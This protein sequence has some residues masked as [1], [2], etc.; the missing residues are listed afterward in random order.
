MEPHHPTI[1]LLKSGAPAHELTPEDRA[2]GLAT[3]RRKQ[4]ERSRSM[5]DRISDEVQSKAETILRAYMESIKAGD[6]RAAE[7]LLDRTFG[8]ATQ[9]SEVETTTKAAEDMSLSELR[10]ALYARL[11]GTESS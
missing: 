3:R 10:A 11:E 2:R 1:R 5:L 8:K 4:A 7:A 9:R 6:W